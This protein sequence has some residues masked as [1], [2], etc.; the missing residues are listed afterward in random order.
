VQESLKE[1]KTLNLCFCSDSN[2]RGALPGLLFFIK[3]AHPET[4]LVIHFALPASETGFRDEVL[5]HARH[6]GLDCRVYD[7]TP[8][9]EPIRLDMIRRGRGLHG[10]NHLA[11]GRFFL[12]ELLP[13]EVDRCVYLDMDVLVF[14]NLE[15][16]PTLLARGKAVAAIEDGALRRHPQN[17][18]GT[19]WGHHLTQLGLPVRNTGY[20]NSGVLVLSLDLWRKRNL[21]RNFSEARNALLLRGGDPAFEDQDILNVHL[22]ESL[23]PLPEIWNFL[24]HS[25]D[26]KSGETDPKKSIRILHFAGAAKPWESFRWAGYFLNEAGEF[27]EEAACR[28]GNAGKAGSLQSLAKALRLLAEGK[29]AT[30]PRDNADIIE[31]LQL[32]FLDRALEIPPGFLPDKRTLLKMTTPWVNQFIVDGMHKILRESAHSGSEAFYRAWRHAR[33]SR[34]GRRW[35]RR[36]LFLTQLLKR[37]PAPW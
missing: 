27:F 20:F 25:L 5:G 1:S 14:G 10:L 37:K 30:T 31:A 16:L 21:S 11:Y 36:C 22:G 3:K 7:I 26:E 35:V 9:L 18:T 15:E 13:D 8:C 23:Q 12:A 2:F 32:Q 6:F 28:S 19:Y 4:D 34:I 33:A 17:L 24:S 29:P